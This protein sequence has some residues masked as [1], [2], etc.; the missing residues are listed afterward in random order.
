MDVNQEEVQNY[1][2][3]HVSKILHG[4]THRPA[5]HE[6]KVKSKKLSTQT[7]QRIVL[8]DWDERG[9]WAELYN[10]RLSLDHCC[11]KRLK[12]HPN[13]ALTRD[14]KISLQMCATRNL[15]LES[16]SAIS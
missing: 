6:L 16:T 9:W 3:Y 10:N 15:Q 12:K 13:V 8:G 2:K 1:F 11:I 5:I 7:A 4:H 14:F